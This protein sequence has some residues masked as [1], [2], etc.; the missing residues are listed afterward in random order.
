[1]NGKLKL[2]IIIGV[3]V[4]L[5]AIGLG[6]FFTPGNP[7][8]K[9]KPITLA[10]YEQIEREMSYKEVVSILGKGTLDS[11]EG[12]KGSKDQISI[13]VWNGK[14]ESSRA[15]VVFHGGLVASKTH[16]GLT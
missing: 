2:G 3:P 12:K 1:M 11:N 8:E 5:I 16:V 7:F 6:L 9:S 15:V 4:L 14:T 13:Y 10:Q